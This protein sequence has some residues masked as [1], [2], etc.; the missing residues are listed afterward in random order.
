MLPMRRIGVPQTSKLPSGTHRPINLRIEATF[1]LIQFTRIPQLASIAQVDS[2]LN[3]IFGS[4]P[5]SM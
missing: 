1:M 4:V 2:S 5:A 3:L